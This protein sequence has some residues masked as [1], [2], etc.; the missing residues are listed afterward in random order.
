[1]K[2]IWD[3]PDEVTTG[4][5]RP[6]W[7]RGVMGLAC[8]LIDVAGSRFDGAQAREAGSQP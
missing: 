4:I 6:G 8:H 1:M 2:P 7:L 3:K 5:A